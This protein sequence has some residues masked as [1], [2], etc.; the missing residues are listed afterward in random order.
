MSSANRKPLIK[1]LRAR[2]TFW[3]LFTLALTLGLFTALLYLALSRTL[4]RHHDDELFEQAM[5]LADVLSGRPLTEAPI[6][7]AIEGSRATSRFVMIR[8]NRGELLYRSPVLQFAEPNIGL[9]EVLIHAAAHGAQEPQFF[10][11]MLERSGPVRFVCVP[12]NPASSAYLQLGNPLGDVPTTLESVL[13]ACLGLVPLV[14]VLTSFGGWMI[15]R[16]ALAPM[17]SI[18]AT[19]QA[20][21]ATDLS[22]RIDTRPADE[23][24]ARLK[25][26][27]NQ[28]LDRLDRAFVSLREFAGDVSHQLQTPL[29]V[30]HGSLDDALKAEGRPDADQRLLEDL[31]EEIRDMSAI[32]S[33][34][35]DLALADASS[36]VDR[37]EAVD[38]SE[39]VHEAVEI[40]S[41]LGEPR[42]VSVTS[43]VEPG[44]KTRGDKTRLKQVALNLGDN[45]VKYTPAGG[46]VT[47]DLSTESREA[48][49]RVTDSGMGIAAKHLPHVFDRFYRI[50]SARIGTEGTGLG[51]A[52]VKRIVEVHGGTV[53]AQS[54][55]GAGSTFTVRLPLVQ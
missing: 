2:L 49:L 34:L 8:D 45:A 7:E 40:I 18:D 37:R 54:R 26:T 10:T 52:I 30:L 4:Q 16:R 50:D 9:H 22:K 20:I 55:V 25:T 21:Q 42:Q 27:L 44:I 43:R 6:A 23:E 19:L 12:L 51:L 36:P 53:D 28:L 33:G 5:G 39:T 41:A 17:R 14:L 46:R 38:L 29:T 32:V 3:Y 48:V 13:W 15:A 24:L 47:V 1:T 31:A 35:R 11:A